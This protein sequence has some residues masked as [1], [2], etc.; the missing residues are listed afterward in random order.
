MNEFEQDEFERELTRALP[1]VD[2]PEGL[3]VR[4]MERA[5]G[6]AAAASPTPPA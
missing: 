4:I 2:A 1:R 3:A 6:P 5:A